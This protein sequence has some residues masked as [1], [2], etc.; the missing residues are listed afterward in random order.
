MSSGPLEIEAKYS[1]AEHEPVRA[2]L[3]AAGATRLGCVMETNRFFDRSDE[4]LRHAGCGLRVRAAEVIDGEPVSA[5]ITFKGP[6]RAGAMKV[7]PEFELNVAD[8]HKAADL[9]AQLGFAEFFAFEKRRETWRLRDCLVELDELP[10]IGRYVEVEG[11]AEAS[12]VAV[13]ELVGLSTLSIERASYLALL[14]RGVDLSHATR[15]LRLNP[16]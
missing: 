12:V 7:R 16:A 9:L 6:I 8:A 15:F 13:A 5:T 1:V 11:P 2:K 3:R 4:S 10:R 14:M